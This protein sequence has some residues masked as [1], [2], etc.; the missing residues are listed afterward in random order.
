[1]LTDDWVDANCSQRHINVQRINARVNQ[2]L[3][4]RYGFENSLGKC[5]SVSVTENQEPSSLV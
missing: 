3:Y 4:N 1:M 2:W 5:S